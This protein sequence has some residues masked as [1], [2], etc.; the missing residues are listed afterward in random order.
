MLTVCVHLTLHQDLTPSV[1]IESLELFQGENSN[2][3]YLF[4][5][6]ND[7]CARDRAKYGKR[8]AFRRLMERCASFRRTLPFSVA[9][10]WHRKPVGWVDKL[11]FSFLICADHLIICFVAAESISV[12]AAYSEDEFTLDELATNGSMVLLMVDRAE[13]LASAEA[14]NM[15]GFGVPY[16]FSISLSITFSVFIHQARNTNYYDISGLKGRRP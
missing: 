8:S 6:I 9:K 15:P 10:L 11:A 1:P 13:A 14:S 12:E 4:S 2:T 16:G 3:H 7:Y 5:C